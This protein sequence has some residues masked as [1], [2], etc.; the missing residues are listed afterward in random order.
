M[1]F[2]T[3]FITRKGT[4]R[5]R[6]TYFTLSQYIFSKGFIVFLYRLRFATIELY[7]HLL[8]FQ[9]YS[10]AKNRLPSSSQNISIIDTKF[11]DPPRD[12]DPLQNLTSSFLAPF[13]RFCTIRLTDQTNKQTDRSKEHMLPVNELPSS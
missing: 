7:C 13:G 5:P 8:D 2:E 4:Q 10:I 6:L 9:T 1:A 12:S 3:Y 11:L